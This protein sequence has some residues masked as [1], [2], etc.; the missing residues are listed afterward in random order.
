METEVQVGDVYRIGTVEIMATE[1]RMPCQKLAARF[2]RPD[3]QK[4]FATSGRS[5][6]YF[7]VQTE[8][9]LASG[10][11]IVR[12]ASGAGDLTIAQVVGLRMGRERNP[13][14]FRRALDHPV[15][16]DDWKETLS[17]LAD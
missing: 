10:D 14:V 4:L 12:V 1:P 6:I 2:G 15:L 8:G 7:A 13:E 11:R 17:A 5:G 16:G 9:T 3:M